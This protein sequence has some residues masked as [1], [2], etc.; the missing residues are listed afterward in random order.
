MIPVV[1]GAVGMNC[2]AAD[3]VN[4]GFGET[5]V[6]SE[7]MMN[8]MDEGFEVNLQYKVAVEFLKI[9]KKTK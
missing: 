4:P 5:Y 8:T 3:V 6:A 2:D 9:K 1:Q 7:D